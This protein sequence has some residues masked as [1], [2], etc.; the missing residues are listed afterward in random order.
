M[1]LKPAVEATDGGE[2]STASEAPDLDGVPYECAR[3][4]RVVDEPTAEETRWGFF[5]DGLGSW[6]LFCGTCGRGGRLS[7]RGCR[8]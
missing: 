5:G 6:V 3:R 8:R 4:G 7:G 1:P 2:L